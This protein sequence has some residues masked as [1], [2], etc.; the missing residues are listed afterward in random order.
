MAFHLA[1]LE[2]SATRPGPGHGEFVL[3]D[4]VHL[5]NFAHLNVCRDHRASISERAYYAAH[6]HRPLYVGAHDVAEFCL[7]DA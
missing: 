4:D 3:I 5:R 2:T 7:K 6:L 1:A